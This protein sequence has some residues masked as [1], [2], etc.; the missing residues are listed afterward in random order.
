MASSSH[1]HYHNES[2]DDEFDSM[3]AEFLGFNDPFPEPKE[4]KKEFLQRETEKKGIEGFGLII[5]PRIQYIQPVYS[6]AGLE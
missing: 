6:G 5:F 1:Y 2:D 4:R 3:A